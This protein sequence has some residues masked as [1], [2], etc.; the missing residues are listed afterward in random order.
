MNRCPHYSTCSAPLCPDDSGLDEAAWFPGEEIC[1]RNGIAFA[2]IQRRIT[3]AGISSETCF[4]VVM[5]RRNIPVTKTLRGL[6]P[7]VLGVR[8]SS[9]GLLAIKAGFPFPKRRGLGAGNSYS[10]SK[11]P[12][13]SKTLHRHRLVVVSIALGAKICV[14]GLGTLPRGSRRRRGPEIHERARPG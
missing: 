3:R 12:D 8:R 14:N 4:T 7:S 10:D 1:R 2:A 13:R 11:G 6:T 9:H 5:L